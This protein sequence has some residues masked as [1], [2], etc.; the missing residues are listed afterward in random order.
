MKKMLREELIKTREKFLN[1]KDYE[2]YHSFYLMADL[3]LIDKENAILVFDSFALTEDGIVVNLK[4]TK[5]VKIKIEDYL[6]LAKYAEERYMFQFSFEINDLLGCIYNIE[7]AN[8]EMFEYIL[9]DLIEKDEMDLITDA[10]FGF[11]IA[12]TIF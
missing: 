1:L 12:E 4:N 5:K 3:K 8:F 6:E 9:K 2:K 10:D 11:V 7:N